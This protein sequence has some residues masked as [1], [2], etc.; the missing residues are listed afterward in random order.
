MTYAYLRFFNIQYW[1]C[2][3]SSWFGG[4]CTDTGFIGSTDVSANGSLSAGSG[5][6]AP[7]SFWDW[8][9]GVRPADA[10]ASSGVVHT[11]F[12]GGIENAV[13]FLGAIFGGVFGFLWSAVSLLSF[14][15]SFLLLLVVVVSVVGLVVIR[16]EEEERYGNL[17]PA[18]ERTHP[19]RARW[20]A[21]IESAMSQ[22]PKGWREAI[23]GADVLLGELFARLG[24]PGAD[25]AERIKV[26]PDGAF[27]NL[28]SAW[29][30]HRVKNLVA[31]AS[32]HF[33]LTQRE[34]FRVMK[35]YEQV[36]KEF[37]FV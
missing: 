8:L 16:L 10:S 13:A 7:T 12:F 27:A 35:L 32:S 37:D 34:A 30:A 4:R 9:F 29:E 1:Y 3:I 18:K 26:V 2:V 19:L 5:N 22:N 33:I 23:I 31:T 25:T 20:Q 21:L 17:P 6:A 28:G 24:Y 36:F 14:L 11:G 15:I